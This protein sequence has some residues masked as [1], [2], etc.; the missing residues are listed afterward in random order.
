MESGYST[1]AGFPRTDS[2]YY[3]GFLLRL[4][5]AVINLWDTWFTE[6]QTSSITEVFFLEVRTGWPMHSYGFRYRV[7]SSIISSPGIFPSYSYVVKQRTDLC[8]FS[9]IKLGTVCVWNLKE[10]SYATSTD[11]SNYW[12]VHCNYVIPEQQMSNL[13][14]SIADAWSLVKNSL[15]IIGDMYLSIAMKSLLLIFIGS[16]DEVVA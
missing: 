1:Y 5:R 11:R 6:L 7:L 4:S 16:C 3:R 14:T 13:S 10:R 9:C 15:C 8:S 12:I 2:F